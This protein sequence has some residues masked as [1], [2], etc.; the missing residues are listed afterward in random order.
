MSAHKC[1]SIFFQS[2]DVAT[3]SDTSALTTKQQ[4]GSGRPLLSISHKCICALLHIS[5]S[6]AVFLSRFLNLQIDYCF[7]ACYYVG[8]PG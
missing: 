1:E 6:S 5:L 8:M 2:S 3:V 4:G 7:Q